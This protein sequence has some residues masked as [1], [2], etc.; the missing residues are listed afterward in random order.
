MKQKQIRGWTEQAG[1]CQGGERWRGNRERAGVSTGQLS[2]IDWTNYK[3]LPDRTGN[4]IQYP[5]GKHG[6]NE[7]KKNRMHKYIYITV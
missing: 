1:G 6:G 4:Y 7:L 3:G 2:C 5:M